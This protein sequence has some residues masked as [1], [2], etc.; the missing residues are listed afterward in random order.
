M[1]GGGYII[2]TPEQDDASLFP[3]VQ[4]IGLKIVSVD[5]RLAPEHPFPAPLEDCYSALLWMASR[6][7]ALD[8]DRKRIALGGNS[9]GAGLAAALAHL[10]QERGEIR[11]VFQLLVYPMLDDRT[12]ARTDID[13]RGHLVW[14]NASN[15]FGWEAYLNQ[16]CGAETVP[17]GSVPARRENLRGLPP[18]WIGVGEND[19]F[20]DE[21]VAYARRLNESGVRCELMTMPGAFHGFDLIVPNSRESKELRRS[22]VQALTHALML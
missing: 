5:Y 10:A 19:L 20:L 22:Q 11:P 12:A 3:L 7:E 13:P 17:Q 6:A 21:S 9:A 14:N 4:E 2:G 1:H 15:R 8:I 16:P 18:A